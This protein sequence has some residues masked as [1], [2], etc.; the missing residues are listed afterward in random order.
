MKREQGFFLFCL[1]S[2]LPFSTWACSC[3]APTTPKA[4]YA[5]AYAVALV[6][7][8][9][10]EYDKNSDGPIVFKGLE[11]IRAWKQ[12]LPERI[13]VSTWHFGMCGYYI[14]KGIHLLYLGAKEG[15]FFWNRRAFSTIECSGNQYEGSERFR[16]HLDWLEEFGVAPKA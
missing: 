14:G 11:V 10:D 12:K 5:G 3:A 2:L 13:D 6:R 4:Y 16:E 8:N 1:L 9:G 7:A 15:R